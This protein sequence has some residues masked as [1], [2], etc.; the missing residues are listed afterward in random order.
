MKA[1]ILAGGLGARL[2]DETTGLPK[3]M[4]EIGGKPLLWHIMKSYS[5]YGINNFIICLGYKG[6]IIKEYFAN[7]FLHVSDVT[8]DIT[9]NLM[10]VHEHNAEPW[11]ITLIDT[12]DQTQTGGRLKRVASYLDDEDFC[13]TY[14]DGLSD[15]DIKKEVAFHKKEGSLATLMSVQPPARFGSIKMDTDNKIAGFQEKPQGAEGWVNGG[16]YILSPKSLDYIEGD[17]TSWEDVSPGKLKQDGRLSNYPHHG[18]WQ[19][20]DTLRDKVHLEELWNSN[21]APWK[22]W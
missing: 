21:K 1:V 7:Y 12:G 9:N 2:G 3:P 5:F 14:G 4:I 18:F 22:I 13:L 6:Y 8:F 11:K 19:T 17:E 10:E 15:V 20:L 16:F